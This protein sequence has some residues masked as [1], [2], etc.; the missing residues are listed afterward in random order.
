LVPGLSTGIEVET[1]LGQSAD[2]SHDAIAL[3]VFA[4]RDNVPSLPVSRPAVSDLDRG[5]VGAEISRQLVNK[6]AFAVRGLESWLAGT[7]KKPF[8]PK[9]RPSHP[10]LNT[11][12]GPS[13]A[14]IAL[15]SLRS[16]GFIQRIDSPGTKRSGADKGSPGQ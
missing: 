7:N 11:G 3:D 15:V 6:K 16:S 2:N 5:E 13:S 9:H 10:Y 4:C 12:K 1:G 8:A 14:V